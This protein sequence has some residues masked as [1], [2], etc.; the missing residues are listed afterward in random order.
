MHIWFNGWSAEW[1]RELEADPTSLQQVVTNLA[2]NARDAM[3]R[4]GTL[5]MRVM[6]RTFDPRFDPPPWPG[7]RAGSWI[8]LQL[9]DTGCGIAPEHLPHIFEP[10]FTTKGAGKGTGLGLSQVY[11]IVQQHGGYIGVESQVGRGSTFTV[12]LPELT[13]IGPLDIKK[14]SHADMARVCGHGE[15]ILLVEDDEQVRE[16]CRQALA[17]AG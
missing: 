6:R 3:P 2:V 1:R 15:R 17:S 9:E 13:V 4:G 10:F 16:I 7:M 5:W 8:L 14:E 12:Y 11:G